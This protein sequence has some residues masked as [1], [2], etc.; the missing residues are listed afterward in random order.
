[1]SEI[2]AA[3]AE[4]LRRGAYGLD[5]DSW[6]EMFTEDAVYEEHHLGV[7]HG[8]DEIRQWIRST[9]GQFPTMSFDTEWTLIDGDRVAMYVWNNLPDPGT[10]KRYGFVNT[11]ILT[12]GGDGLFSAQADFYNPADAERVMGEW[13]TDGGRRHLPV[14]HGLGGIDGWAPDPPTPAHSRDEVESEF[15]AYRE[16]ANRAVATGDWNEWADQFTTDA[17]YREHHFGT[18]TGQDEIR[19]WI[20]GVMKPFPTMEFPLQVGDDRRQPGLRGDPQRVAGAGRGRRLLRLRRQRHPALRRRRAVELRG[21]RVQP[22]RGRAG[23]RRVGRRRGRA[24]VLRTRT[25]AGGTG[26][27]TPR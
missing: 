13:I 22:G 26:G 15:H 2:D 1:M 3:L 20:T 8:R 21:G 19:A 9:M 24:A 5:W 7:F 4:Y 17:R 6:V 25:V 16:R 18:F 12:Y 27:T 23:H 11:S 10:G 14:Q